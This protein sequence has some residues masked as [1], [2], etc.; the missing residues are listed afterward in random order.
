M[1]SRRSFFRRFAGVIAAVALAPEIAFNI[2]L[3]QS[4][5]NIAIWGCR[6]GDNLYLHSFDIKVLESS[7]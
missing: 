6:S 3:K 4:W 5:E 1:A 2:S 7:W